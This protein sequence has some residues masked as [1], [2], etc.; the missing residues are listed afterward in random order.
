M[1]IRKA[2]RSYKGKTYSS[3]LLV[4]SVLTPKGPRQ[5]LICSLGD[6]TP[7]PREQ[8]LALARKLE[9]SLTGQQDLFPAGPADPESERL[10]AKVQANSLRPPRPTASGAV[11]PDEEKITVC[12][13]GVRI[14]ESR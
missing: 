6:L 10:V 13:D 12:T 14:E 4:E 8:W 7:R 9:T 2:T 5:K 11:E 1:Y 3:Y